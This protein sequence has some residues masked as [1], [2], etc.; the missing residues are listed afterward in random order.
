LPKL[1]YESSE[2]VAGENATHVVLKKV[3]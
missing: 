3:R 2:Y 1:G